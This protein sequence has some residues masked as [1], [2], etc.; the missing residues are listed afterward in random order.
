MIL[1]Y[2]RALTP[3][4]YLNR[5][6][7]AHCFITFTVLY[8]VPYLNPSPIDVCM[9]SQFLANKFDSIASVKNYMSGA[10]TWVLE[11]GG[12]VS[13]FGGYEHSMMIKAISKDSDHVVKRAFPLLADHIFKIVCYLDCARNVPLCIKPCILIGFSCYLRS[14]NLVAPCLSVLGGPHTL[15]T[16]NIVDCG[17]NLKILIMSTK[18]K[19]VPYSVS[20]PMG[21]IPQICPVRAWRSYRNAVNPP[22]NGPAFVLN[23]VTPLNA[24]LVVNFMRDA[25]R[26]NSDLDVQSI[27]M[28]S[29]RRGAVQ[30]AAKVG[31]P[32][33][34]IMSRGG[35]A[36]RSG[37]RP[38]LSQ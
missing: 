4:T 17:S 27:S 31:S 32:I 10:R 5:Q 25:L 3:G 33:P 14:S 13:A 30:Q 28:H 37:I 36:S 9:Y 21:E 6:K 1:T 23:K 29:L 12:N 15:F 7:Q 16:K 26:D 20:I 38:Y 22:Q 18:T 19:R 24:P 34:D 11:H 35:W 8:N 2:S